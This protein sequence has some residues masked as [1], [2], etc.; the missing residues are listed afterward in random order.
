MRVAVVPNWDELYRLGLQIG[1]ISSAITA[2]PVVKTPIQKRLDT[3]GKILVVLA[4]VLCALVVVIGLAWRRPALDMVEVGISLGVSV[5]PEGLVAVVT[6]TMALGVRR[7]ASKNAIVRK[8]PS[9]ETLG[10]VTVICSDK[11]G[12]L[13]EGR[14]GA[15]SV[16][17][18]NDVSYSFS[19]SADI[20]PSH[21]GVSVVTGKV[22]A[23]PDYPNGSNDQ[24]TFGVKDHGLDLDPLPTSL[25]QKELPKSIALAPAHLV[26]ASSVCSMCNNSSVTAHEGGGL[27]AT[28]DPTEIALLVAAARAGFSREYF[29][30]SFEKLGENAFDSDRKL[31]SVIYRSRTVDGRAVDPYSFIVAKGAPESLLSRCMS[32]VRP[33]L[34]SSDRNSCTSFI[35]TSVEN[36]LP[37]N[38]EFENFVSDKSN[39]LAGHG[40]RVLGLAVRIVSADEGLLIAKSGKPGIAENNLTFVGLIGLIDP[41]KPGVRE[42]VKECQTAGIKVVMITGDHIATANRAMRGEE[43]DLLSEDALAELRPFPNVFAR[44]SPENKLNIVKAL[45]SKHQFVSMTGDGVNDAPAIKRADVGIAMGKA[46]TE[47]TKQAADIVLADDDFVTIVAAVKEGRRVFDNILKFLIYLWVT[48]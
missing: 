5:V 9:V 10:S 42:A 20:D 45:Q 23:V 15:A 27:K 24:A 39:E 33:S 44:V 2:S 35:R 14:M 38:E 19:K 11:T 41:P 4:L 21:G 22:S 32:F 25:A 36:P 3:L 47:I 37:L 29:L 7:M 48:I 12:T 16:W 46:G 31:M 18:T 28:G 43:L 1:K 40:L 13:T 26:L 30:E 6:L 17:T 34:D 8:L